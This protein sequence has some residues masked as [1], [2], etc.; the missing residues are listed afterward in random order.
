M[1]F[2]TLLGAVGMFLV[3]SETAVFAADGAAVYKASCAK[4]HG[5]DG[6]ADT[7]VGKTLKVPALAGDAKVA[8]AS[9]AD[10]VK[11]IKENPKHSSFSGKLSAEDVDAVAAYVKTL[12][13]AK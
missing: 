4:C 7:T 9:Q 2:R 3:A 1:R 12:G 13:G 5:D 11:R 10:V 6:R 8:E